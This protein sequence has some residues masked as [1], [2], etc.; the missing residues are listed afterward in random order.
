MIVGHQIRAARALLDWSAQ[1]LADKVNLSREAINKIEDGA[2]QAR[3]KNLADIRR[4]LEQHGIE[5]I[6]ARGA[7]FADDQI[8]T[9][10]GENVFVRL[11]DDVIA[12]LRTVEGAEALFA[13]VDDH[14]SPPIVVENY[15][16]LRKAGIAMRSLVKEGDTY[17]MGKLAEYR[18]LPAARFHNNATVI[19]GTKFATVI[20][21][22]ETGEDT[23]AVIVHNQHVAAAQRNIFEFVWEHAQKPTEST[24]EVRYDR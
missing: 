17:L 3:A 20:R 18:C 24:A 15:R 21:D 11:L 6:G 16:R 2:V 19:Y 14:A 22:P 9:L 13:C 10:T 1:V 5:F 12:T 4:V 23:A 8:V 7:A